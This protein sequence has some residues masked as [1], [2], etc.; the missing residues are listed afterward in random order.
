LFISI[1]AVIAVL[2]VM[3]LSHEL[4]HFLMAK[5]MGVK[6]EAFSLGFGPK[7]WS[8]KKGETEYILSAVPM[9]GYVKMAGEEPGGVRKGEEWE[10][11]SKPVHKRFNIIVSGAAVN[12]LLGFALF[13]MIFMA[14]APMRTSRIGA[15]LE[16]Y[17]ASEIGLRAG[18]RIISIEGREIEFWEDVLNI[19][20]NRKEGDILLCVERDGEIL[21]F[22]V[23]GRSEQAKDIFGRTRKTTM[24]GIGPSDDV[25]FVKYGFLKSVSMGAKTTWNVTSLTYRSIWGMLTGSVSIKAV[26]GPIM[27][28]TM[29]G[30]AARMGMSYLL[31]ISALI[32]ISLAIINLL[33]FPV[34]DGGHILFLAIEKIIGR[35][36][37]RKVQEAAQN[38]CW[39]LLIA[40]LLVV[41]R[42]DIMRY[43]GK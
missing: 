36:I 43:L 7:L 21:D 5:K 2:S 41:S 38:I 32:S 35:P 33:P 16:G 25:E 3:I 28:V 29:T 18:D 17:P 26:G 19:I 11:F 24:I 39:V 22:T 34:L 12:Y 1:I 31:W 15:V 10:F 9:G 6:V 13:C 27:I 14:G 8:V 40:L 30:R 42:N 4:G 23:R 37:D 20:H